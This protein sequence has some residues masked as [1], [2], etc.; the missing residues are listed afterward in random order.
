MSQSVSAALSALAHSSGFLLLARLLLT[1][2]FWSDALFQ[3]AAFDAYSKALERFRLRPG[4]AF[5]GATMVFKLAASLMIVSDYHAWV[6]VIALSVFVLLTIPIAHAF[7]AKSGEAA[8]NA[9]NFAMEH[10]SLIGGLLLA[11]L[12]SQAGGP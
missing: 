12:L 11:G 3:L 8:F 4:W 9:R 7:W 1:F 5:N 2:A 6:A 10:V